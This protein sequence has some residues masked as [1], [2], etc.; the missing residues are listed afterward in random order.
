MRTQ[1]SEAKQDGTNSIGMR[2][3]C[4][5]LLCVCACV[6]M[7]QCFQPL[8]GAASYLMQMIGTIICKLSQI[9]SWAL[10]LLFLYHLASTHDSETHTRTHIGSGLVVGGCDWHISLTEEING[11]RT[12][13]SLVCP[14]HAELWPVWF[15]CVLVTLKTHNSDKNRTQRHDGD[16]AN[17]YKCMSTATN[18]VN[19]VTF[20]HHVLSFNH[21]ES[22]WIMTN[23]LSSLMQ[24]YLLV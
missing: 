12:C 13:L 3:S 6:C 9:S 4:V 22:E 24:F 7:F 21:I 1:A 11:G 2:P 15:Q 8:Y 10:A 19:V 20:F 16:D 17:H 5:V 14:S 23:C 18:I